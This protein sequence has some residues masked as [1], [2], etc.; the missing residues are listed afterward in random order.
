MAAIVP[1]METGLEL[2]PESCC[3]LIKYSVNRRSTDV[4]GKTQRRE[5]K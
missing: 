2:L 1:K 5:M 3:N 4:E